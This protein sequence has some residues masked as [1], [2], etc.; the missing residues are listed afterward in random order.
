MFRPFYKICILTIKLTCTFIGCVQWKKLLLLF[1]VLRHSA[2][3]RQGKS[4]QKDNLPF[5]MVFLSHVSIYLFIYLERDL[6]EVFFSY[7]WIL[8]NYFTALPLS[9]VKR[10]FFSLR[11]LNFSYHSI[12]F[13][14]S[15]ANHIA[16]EHSRN[17]Y[18]VLVNVYFRKWAFSCLLVSC[19]DSS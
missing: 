4:K 13:N 17:W 7:V 5:I 12:F 10:W 16:Y 14:E 19:R 15:M 6:C 18:E 3:W 8:S 11:S 9:P 1:I 2:I